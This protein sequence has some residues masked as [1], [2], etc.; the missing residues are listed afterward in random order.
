MVFIG[1]I[2]L[3]VVC[4]GVTTSTAIRSF[5]VKLKLVFD[6]GGRSWSAGGGEMSVA[7]RSRIIRR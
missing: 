5:Y 1:R 3:V 6:S 4:A 2:P 7:L